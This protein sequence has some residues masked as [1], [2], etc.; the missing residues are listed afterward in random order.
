MYDLLVSETLENT[1]KKKLMQQQYW[2]NVDT[3]HKSLLNETKR[4][5]RQEKKVTSI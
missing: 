2:K 4:K 1:K 5:K 3:K